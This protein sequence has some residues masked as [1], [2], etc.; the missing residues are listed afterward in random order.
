MTHAVSFFERANNAH[1]NSIVII[2]ADGTNLGI[3]RKTHIPDGPGYQV[4]HN[5]AHILQGNAQVHVHVKVFFLC[6]HQEKFYFNPGDTGFK[7]F[8]TRFGRIGVAIC[9]DQ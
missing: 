7:V 2:D 8:D 6:T 9:W 5:L 4:W 1:Y 3:Y